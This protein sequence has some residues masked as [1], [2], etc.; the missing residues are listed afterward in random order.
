MDCSCSFYEHV[1]SNFYFKDNCLSSIWV[2]R[3]IRR[4]SSQTEKNMSTCTCED[5][6]ADRW[7]NITRILKYRQRGMK[8]GLS[9]CISDSSPRDILQST[10]NQVSA[11]I[12]FRQGAMK[13]KFD[14]RLHSTSINQNLILDL[15]WLR[16]GSIKMSTI[17]DNLSFLQQSFSRSTVPKIHMVSDHRTLGKSSLDELLG[18]VDKTFKA[19]SSF[20]RA[21]GPYDREAIFFETLR[22]QVGV[23]SPYLSSIAFDAL[24]LNFATGT[25]ERTCHS[26]I[27]LWNPNAIAEGSGS[28]LRDLLDLCERRCS[29]YIPTSGNIDTCL[30]HKV[31]VSELESTDGVHGCL[32]NTCSDQ[33]E[34][35]KSKSCS[36]TS[37]RSKGNDNIT[38]WLWGAGIISPWLYYMSV[39]S[40]FGCHIEDYAFG[41]ANVIIAPPGAQTWVVW[42]S[43]SRDDIGNLHE[44]LHKFLGDK[45]SLDCLEQ[46]KL[47]L[48]PESV[49]AWRGLR[50]QQI[51]VYHHLQGPSEYVVT[52]YGAVH[53]GVNIGVGWKAAVNFAFCDWRKAAQDIHTVYRDLELRTGEVR[54]YRCV[55]D[56]DMVD[57]QGLPS[58][59][60]SKTS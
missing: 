3:S 45:Y 35:V 23:R 4:N 14:D 17:K 43:V 18:E 25:V 20:Y 48:D 7:K 10:S 51:T 19:F 54:N 47:W 39:G 44:Y 37:T 8:E 22:S 30:K 52:D 55:P 1:T 27:H 34:T 56:F 33:N 38:G 42:Y 6:G 32:G 21:L 58:N 11:E 15:R 28:F 16:H 57:W 24:R 60:R 46:R 53:W 5:L 59:L 50:G 31:K 2:L 13:L 40:V 12:L 9:T 36:R 49:A 26:N 29:P 41:S